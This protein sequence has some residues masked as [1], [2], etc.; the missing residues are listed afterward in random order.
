MP[1]PSAPKS[2]TFRHAVLV[3]SLFLFFAMLNLTLIVAGLRE[4]ILVELGGTAQDASLFFSIEMLAYVVFAPVWGLVS[5]RAGRRRPFVVVGFFLTSLV[6]VGLARADA[7]PEL[8]VLRFLQGAASVMG[9]STLMAMVLDQPDDRKRG[10]Y[11]GIMGAALTFGVSLGAPLGGFVTRAG[12]ARAPLWTSAG[13]FLALAVAA[14]F[15]LREPEAKRQQT[16]VGEILA[17]L[18]ARPRLLLPYLF[19]FVDRY[20]VGFFVIVFPLY[21]A[22]NGV[23][24]PGRR[25]LYLAAFMI[26][27]AALQ[28]PTGR[29]AERLGPWRPL[30][31]GSFCYGV[32]LCVV[33]YSSL[34]ALWW[35]MAG[36]GMLAAVMFPPSI[37]LT[38]QLSDSRTRGSAMGGFNLAGSLGF[39]VGPLVGTWANA[40]HGYGFAFIVSG[41]LEIAVVLAALAWI[42]RSRSH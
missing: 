1:A 39:A 34:F 23:D 4:L 28:Y 17:T 42:V 11:M 30:L 38:A 29:L 12:G 2:T 35:V 32:L 20:T 18:A 7:I 27:F 8:L 25:G 37:I 22:A 21:L 6:Y 9:W 40:L 15:L 14:L 41:A 26:P 13:L 5:D 36:L 19:H 10:R 31:W 33:G 3:P 16:G 24:D